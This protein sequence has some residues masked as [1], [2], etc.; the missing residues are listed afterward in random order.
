MQRI[1]IIGGTGSGKTTL[2]RKLGIHLGIPFYD[3]DEVGYEGGSGA[4]RPIDV[5]LADLKC[6]AA[7]SAWITEG[8]FILWIDELLQAADTIVW[9]DLPWRIRRWRIITRHIKA[10][11]ARNNR[12][13]GYLNLYRFYK[14]SRNYE[15][16]PTIYTLQTPDGDDY[17]SHATVVHKLEQYK[18]KVLHCCTIADVA[19]FERTITLG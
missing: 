9:L 18:D 6:I 14:R 16:D 11:F 7:Q 19:A 17:M 15:R 3:L 13:A 5:R 10:D 2:A 12:H 8:G 1:H 4:K